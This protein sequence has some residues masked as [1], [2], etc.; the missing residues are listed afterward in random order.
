MGD[1][2]LIPGLGRSLEKEKATHSSILAWRTL[3]IA[4]VHGVAKSQTQLRDF[5]FT[6]CMYVYFKI[7]FF[8]TVYYRILNIVPCLSILYKLAHI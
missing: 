6:L 5:Y 7:F 1:L 4:I 3:W 8:V 2:G